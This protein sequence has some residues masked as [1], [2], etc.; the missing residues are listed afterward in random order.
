MSDTGEDQLNAD[1]SVSTFT[2]ALWFNAALAGGFFTG[3]CVLRR[4]RPSVYSPR[5]YLVEKE[6]QPPPLPDGF[7]A[8]IWTLIRIPEKEVLR[9]IGLDRF[10][11]LRFLR[12]GI[13]IFTLFTLVAIPILIPVNLIN[14]LDSPG[15]NKLTMGNIKDPDR[16]WAH[17]VL[18]VLLS[19]GVVYYT[20]RETRQYLVLRRLHLLSPEYANS[21]TARMLYVPSIPERVNNIEELTKIFN[22]FPGGVRRIW[23]TRNVKDLPDIVDERQKH[24]TALEGAI[25][26]SI[27]ASYKYYA[28][29]G[30]PELEDRPESRI[31]EKLRPTHRVSKLPIPL[32]FV[33]RKVDS[34]DYYH[35]EIKK[36]NEKITEAQRSPESYDQLSS[37][38]IEFNQQIAAH[39]AAQCV[40]HS[41]EMTMAPRYIQIASTDIIWENMNVK[42]YERLGRRAIS[43]VITSAIVIFWAIPVAFVQLVANIDSLSKILPF[44][45]G[46]KDLPSTL[47][48]IIQGILPAVALAILI[49]LV[50][51][52]FRILSKNEGIPQKS[53][54]DLSLLHKY[55]F[56]LF[57]DVVLVSTIVGGAI[58]A[59]S[60]FLKNPLSII[61]ILAE[62]LPKASTFFITYVLLQALNGTGQAILQAVPLV[63][64]YLLP[65]LS[66]TPRD[67]YTR[68][69]KCPTINLGTLIPSHTVIFVLGLLYSTIAPL[70]LPFVCL[71]FYLTYFI[72]LYQFLYLYEMEYESGG[73]AFPRAIR[74][75]YIGLFTWQL[76]MIGLLA[77]QKALPQMIIMIIT[78]VVSIFGLALYDKAFKP[79]FKYLPI[80]PEEDEKKAVTTTK[81][82]QTGSSF[83]S[84][85]SNILEEEDDKK[86]L[87]HDDGVTTTQGEEDDQFDTNLA[88]SKDGLVRRKNGHVKSSKRESVGVVDAY[89][90]RAQLQKRIH[91][92]PAH[93]SSSSTHDDGVSQEM[94]VSSARLMYEVQSYMHPSM[95]RRQPTVW[96][97]EDDIG[98]TEHE[99]GQLK[100][101]NIRTSNFGAKAEHA[102]KKGQKSRV[103]VDEAMYVHG[104]RGIP[105]EMPTGDPNFDVNDYVR[106][107]VD[108]YALVES[109][110]L[111]TSM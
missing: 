103:Q 53:M 56:F 83:F 89:N 11:V 44:L 52:V 2:S 69:A 93:P 101:L 35:E 48:G 81:S 105:G 92:D 80:Q 31:P 33:G 87:T 9:S 78:L 55:F 39:M 88:M 77:I 90:A 40:T 22:R 74:H 107:V 30:D 14:Q 18:A 32:P 106:H 23:L 3:F 100:E 62:S 41:R 42:S 29:K 97:P 71:F 6:R 104:G 99:M 82:H 25:T 43:L 50:P 67:I 13:V 15:L 76:T 21:V 79:L 111:T 36:L 63:L 4:L 51:V 46:L 20:F 65:F 95:Y 70:I 34:I 73:L 64:S 96:L 75:V 85:G 61:N 86:I 109:L 19:A 91:D 28:K 24:V 49:S 58:Q 59:I 47:V 68:K 45:A 84:T 98:I 8:W 54:V 12:M 5:S 57:V 27:A 60:E 16:I 108:S 1:N 26:K 17:L 10:M 110:A 94:A 7:L 102:G 37:A 38:Y 72:Y 66:V